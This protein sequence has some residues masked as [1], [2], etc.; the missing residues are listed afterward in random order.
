MSKTITG[1]AGKEYNIE[2][3]SLR[4]QWPVLT[5]PLQVINGHIAVPDGPG[6]GIELNDEMVK[7][8]SER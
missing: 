3:I 6:L 8:L 4:D 1:A 5:E 2:P 7:F